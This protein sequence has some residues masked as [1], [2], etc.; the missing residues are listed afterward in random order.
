MCKWRIARAN[1]RYNHC[2][3][4]WS[5]KKFRLGYQI[6]HT[7]NT[8]RLTDS[9]NIKYHDRLM[10][11]FWKPWPTQQY[12]PREYPPE[13]KYPSTTLFHS[14]QE[15]IKVN[16]LGVIS[17]NPGFETL[18]TI[19]SRIYRYRSP[20]SWQLRIHGLFTNPGGRWVISVMAQ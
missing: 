14:R 9:H 17:L 1:S 20:C 2:L 10:T 15:P 4:A 12:I 11:L 16:P 13:H 18:Y 6:N 5:T 19:K 3:R 7:G 8:S